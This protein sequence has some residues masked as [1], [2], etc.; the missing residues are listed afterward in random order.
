MNG[1][2]ESRN[3]FEV[4]DELPVVTFGC[5]CH[6]DDPGRIEESE[7]GDKCLERGHIVNIYKHSVK[8]NWLSAE[9]RFKVNGGF[10]VDSVSDADEIDEV[11]EGDTG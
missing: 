1:G 7:E 6:I 9:Y 4:I 10:S 11:N 5:G 2:G 3:Y 8:V